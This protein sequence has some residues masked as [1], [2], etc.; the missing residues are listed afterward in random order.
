MSLTIRKSIFNTFTINNHHNHGIVSVFFENPIFYPTS[1]NLLQNAWFKIIDIDTNSIICTQSKKDN[2]T[3]INCS[4][5]LENT[6]M[7]KPFNVICKSDDKTSK[8]IFPTNNQMH[9]RCSLPKRYEFGR[10]DWSACIKSFHVSNKIFN[11]TSDFKIR[12]R[13]K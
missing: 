6:N 12:L 1:I 8:E 10:E 2:P 11:I 5:K 13:L 4:I 7:L 9:F 3:V